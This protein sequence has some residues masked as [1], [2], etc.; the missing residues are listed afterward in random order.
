MLQATEALGQK[1]RRWGR[2]S[3]ILVGRK[4]RDAK[5]WRRRK[6]WR[7]QAGTRGTARVR[8]CSPT[9][10]PSQAAVLSATNAPRAVTNVPRAYPVPL[11]TN[12]PRVATR[13]TRAAEVVSATK[14][15]FSPFLLDEENSY[16]LIPLSF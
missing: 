6:K 11:A 16:S 9:S 13:G 4:P 8:A 5:K 15:D 12:D 1:C 14:G 3:T 7:P 10:E 2:N